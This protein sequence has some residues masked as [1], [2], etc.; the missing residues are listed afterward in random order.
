M[1]LWQKILIDWIW[2]IIW[3][4]VLYVLLWINNYQHKQLLERLDSLELQVS[5][6]CWN[7]SNVLFNE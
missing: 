3:A 6:Q 1:K 4:T 5:E 2:L 7:L